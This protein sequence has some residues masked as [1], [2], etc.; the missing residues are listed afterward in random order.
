MKYQE[1]VKTE[2]SDK[3]GS[4]DVNSIAL[5]LCDHIEYIDGI[6]YVSS[7]IDDETSC[8]KLNDLGIAVKK[9]TND[10]LIAYLDIDTLDKA[11]AVY[12]DGA[13]AGLLRR[14]QYALRKEDK[15]ASLNQKAA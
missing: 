2:Y 8:K 3:V 14:L 15:T 4:I 12:D 11:K 10:T 7:I 13:T 5:Q 1:I 6:A 9:M